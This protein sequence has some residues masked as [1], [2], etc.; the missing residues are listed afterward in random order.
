ML[1]AVREFGR[2]PRFTAAHALTLDNSTHAGRNGVT[3]LENTRL[4]GYGII[5]GRRFNGRRCNLNDSPGGLE[6][7]KM[8]GS[9]VMGLTVVDTPNHGV[10]LLGLGSASDPAQYNSLSWLK[11]LN[12]RGNGDG[13]HVFQYWNAIH[14]IFLRT[15]DDS[16]YLAGSMRAGSWRRVITWNDTNGVPFIF[17]AAGSHGTALIEDSDVLYHRK[18][19][20]QWCGG[21][22]DLR[23]AN[24]TVR[25]VTIRNIR[26]HD[27]YPT[28][29]LLDL[30]GAMSD[31][32]WENVH[33]AAQSTFRDMN[34]LGTVNCNTPRGRFFL[35][36][37]EV[38]GC[39]LPFGIPQRIVGAVDNTE[40]AYSLDDSVQLNGLSFNDVTV[41]G[42]SI[43]TMFT[44]PAYQ[45][46]AV[47]QGAVSVSFDGVPY[48]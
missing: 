23:D 44:D 40:N 45:G 15:Q 11:V 12:W 10:N 39:V 48:A 46:A 3:R 18:Q 4:F 13:V 1:R 9:E 28:C 24:S 43:G 41:N 34:S 16:M 14:D 35:P 26:I 5:S 17:S 31:V 36:S 29:P 2:L 22:F 25:N 20:P 21:I 37:S 42:T 32:S 30:T 47:V 33:M 6:L 19:L 8:V 38:P 27:P 7:Q